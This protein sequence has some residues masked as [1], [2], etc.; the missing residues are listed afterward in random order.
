MHRTHASPTRPIHQRGKL[1]CYA[2]LQCRLVKRTELRANKVKEERAL[3]ELFYL[4]ERLSV[5]L[6]SLTPL[7]TRRLVA[8]PSSDLNLLAQQ[9]GEVMRD[10]SGFTTVVGPSKLP[11][12]GQGVIV[13]RGKVK[14]GQLVALYPGQWVWLKVERTTLIC[15]R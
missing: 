11:G 12:A 6:P 14:E 15:L 1:T 5:A 3:R 10:V 13:E 9:G 4:M 2:C 8:R 7:Q